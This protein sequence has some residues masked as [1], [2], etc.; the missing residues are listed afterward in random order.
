MY[1]KSHFILI[2]AIFGQYSLYHLKK[3][4]S[5]VQFKGF[6]RKKIKNKHKLYIKRTR[7]YRKMVVN[8]NWN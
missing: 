8:T 1:K 2:M 4:P 5:Q 3:N 7:F 6:K